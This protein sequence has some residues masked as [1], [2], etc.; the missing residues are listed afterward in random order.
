MKPWDSRLQSCDF[1]VETVIGFAKRLWT[2]FSQ[3]A[4]D[5]TRKESGSN[6]ACMAPE[7]IA[8]SAA[9][10]SNHFNQIEFLHSTRLHRRSVPNRAPNDLYRERLAFISCK[11]RQISELKIHDLANLPN[12]F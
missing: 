9:A 5:R 7:I 8:Q 10:H 11:S 3:P 2:W 4:R 6:R 1:F 12:L